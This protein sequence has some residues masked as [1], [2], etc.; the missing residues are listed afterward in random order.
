LTELLLVPIVLGLIEGITEFLP[1][2]ST[3]HLIVA[4]HLL[5][6][7]GPRAATFE[8]F[9]QLGAILAVVWEFR[10][11]LLGAVAGLGR[12]PASFILARNL[13]LG[14]LPAA[15]MGF[16]FNDLID[17]YLFG[18]I[19]VAGALIVGGFV[20][21]AIE[22]AKPA[23]T[24][25]TS[26]EIPA[27]R[28]LAIGCAQT[29]A[30]FPGVSRAAATIMGG[31]VAGVERKAATEFSFYLAIPTMFAASGYKL[32][33][34]WKELS[35]SDLPLFSIGFVVA[36]ASALVAVRVFI[37]YVGTHDFRPFAW[38]RIVF[39]AVVLALFWPK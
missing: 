17:T 37:R 6:F 4:G 28:A 23:A 34:S 18:P 26:P 9:I 14:F 10:R 1:V 35:A 39:G 22:W 32:L 16:L 2:S 7:Q 20:M 5:G 38:Y 24:I 19:T 15:I 12:E 27:S 3:G 21:L 30:L 29:L 11:T 31:M 36:F 33:H 25:Q 8:V 13:A